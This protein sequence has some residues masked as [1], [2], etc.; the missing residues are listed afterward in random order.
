MPFSKLEVATFSVRSSAPLIIVASSW[1]SSPPLPALNG[2]ENEVKGD[3]KILEKTLKFVVVKLE[4]FLYKM[5]QNC[6]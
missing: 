6:F 3:R 4:A 5:Y 2:Q 1:V